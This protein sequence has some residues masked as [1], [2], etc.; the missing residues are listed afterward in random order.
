MGQLK[1]KCMLIPANATNISNVNWTKVAE[2]ESEYLI[3]LIS[4]LSRTQQK[5]IKTD[6][7]KDITHS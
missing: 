3:F 5:C 6:L 7:G 2:N 4:S 1:H